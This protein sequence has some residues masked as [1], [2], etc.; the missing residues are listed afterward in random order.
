M[1]VS[2]VTGLSSP[3]Y[4]RVLVLHLSCLRR[5]GLDP[6]RVLAFSRER[7]PPRGGEQA[8][9]AQRLCRRSSASLIIATLVSTNKLDAVLAGFKYRIL[10]AAK[11][12][13]RALTHES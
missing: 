5:K 2:L 8:N 13:L 6:V 9:G 3:A 4:S 1:N 10:V 11:R 12:F 7:L